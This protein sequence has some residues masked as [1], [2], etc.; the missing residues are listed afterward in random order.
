MNKEASLP[1]SFLEVGKAVHTD[2]VVGHH[3]ECLY[4]K[5]LAG[6][7]TKPVKLLEIGLGFVSTLALNAPS[8]AV[9][10]RNGVW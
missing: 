5:A 3:Y 1:P 7:R 8:S 4:E 2:K 6:L 10:M 9:Q